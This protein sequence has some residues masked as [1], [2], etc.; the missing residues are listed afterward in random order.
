MKV[1]AIVEFA[2]LAPATLPIQVVLRHMTEIG[3]QATENMNVAVLDTER[4]FV[5]TVAPKIRCMRLNRAILAGE[6]HTEVH[7]VRCVLTNNFASL[8]KPL[9]LGHPENLID[10]ASGC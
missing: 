3:L 4:P 9:H 1:Q 8:E 5:R 6:I 2:I 10:R 7:A